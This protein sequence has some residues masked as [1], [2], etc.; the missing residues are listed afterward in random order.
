MSG[1]YDFELLHVADHCHA[2][3]A[4]HLQGG[5]DVL[6]IGGVIGDVGDTFN[7]TRECHLKN[8]IKAIFIPL[9]NIEAD[10]ETAGRCACGPP[11]LIVTHH[12]TQIFLEVGTLGG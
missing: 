7:A 10:T 8:N 1:I 3:F 6:V 5:G 11:D 12:T 4:M 2:A 9:L